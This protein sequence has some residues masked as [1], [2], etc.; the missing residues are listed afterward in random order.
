[1]LG[2]DA[3]TQLRS[4]IHRNPGSQF[5]PW[6]KSQEGSWTDR[7][8]YPREDGIACGDGHGEEDFLWI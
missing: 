5:P 4:S 7:R 8:A 6:I 2:L 3:G 1:M